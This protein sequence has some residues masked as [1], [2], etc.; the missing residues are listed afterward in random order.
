[1]N[2]Q[3]LIKSQLGYLSTSRAQALIGEA[4]SAM[5][6]G[7][8]TTVNRAAMFLAQIGEESGSLR[9]TQEIAPAP[10]AAYKPYIGRTFIQ[11]T[12]KYNY[13]AFGSWC[14]SK[15]L[16]SNPNV[17]VNNPS[18]LADIKWAWWGAVW[19]WT[20]HGLNGF[21][22][23]GDING[24]TQRINGGYNGLAER[25]RRW[26]ACLALGSA[27]L[28]SGVK[29]L[30][31]HWPTYMP[32]NHYFGLITGPNQS[33]GGYYAN[34]RAD[35]AAIQSRLKAL[36]YNVSGDPAGKFQVHTYAAVVAWQKKV[37]PKSKFFGQIWPDD[38]NRLFTY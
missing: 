34:E 32:A 20:T 6:T 28:P 22:D 5:R 11:I 37:A 38:W 33:H 3:T 31:R 25:T 16:V 36:G 12:W 30:H 2:Y 13:A 4:N 18:S 24:A 21:A 7:G 15:G 19:Y 35:V 29:Y 14:Q 23:R 27:I 1:M 8:I 26:H 9:Y 10:N 17:F